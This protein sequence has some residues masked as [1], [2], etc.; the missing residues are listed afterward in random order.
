MNR[1]P[2][3]ATLGVRSWSGW[4]ASQ[5]RAL[6]ATQ[7]LQA[8]ALQ[9]CYPMKTAVLHFFA[10]AAAGL[11]IGFRNLSRGKAQTLRAHRKSEHCRRGHFCCRLI[12]AALFTW[13]GRN[14]ERPSP[15]FSPCGARSPW[16]ARLAYGAQ[17]KSIWYFCRSFTVGWSGGLLVAFACLGHPIIFSRRRD[18]S[19][20]PWLAAYGLLDRRC[21]QPDPLQ[22]AMAGAGIQW[23]PLTLLAATA[24]QPL[25]RSS[26]TRFGQRATIPA[27]SACSQP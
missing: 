24:I 18:A 10:P 26:T 1:W 11:V 21:L 25:W 17:E 23:L 3:A 2:C 27:S 4:G 5:T 16:H 20:Y 8:H 15:A 13:S 19:P 7:C 14:R 9:S 6:S 12:S 22:D